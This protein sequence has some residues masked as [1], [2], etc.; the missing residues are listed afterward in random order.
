MLVLQTATRVRLQGQLEINLRGEES[1]GQGRWQWWCSASCANVCC[2]EATTHT[3][4]WE[5]RGVSRDPGGVAVHAG[6]NG[7]NGVVGCGGWEGRQAGKRQVECR[8]SRQLGRREQGRAGK[9][10]QRLDAMRCGGLM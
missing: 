8:F 5:G 6:Q 2:D 4:A 10:G 3:W 1:G 7:C 9:A